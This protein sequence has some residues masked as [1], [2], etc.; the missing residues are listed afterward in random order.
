[1]KYSKKVYL[2]A[3]PD[4]YFYLK[5]KYPNQKILEFIPGELPIPPEM[6]VNTLDTIDTF[7]FSEG[8]KRNEN[9]ENYLK[10]NASSFYKR[11]ISVSPSTTRKLIRAQAEIYL[12]KKK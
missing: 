3:I 9:V 11:S 5:E 6:F 1:M 4:P 12:R 10:E 2:Q 8:T 7:V